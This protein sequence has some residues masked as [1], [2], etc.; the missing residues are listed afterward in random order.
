MKRMTHEGRK[1]LEK[2]LKKKEMIIRVIGKAM[3]RSHSTTYFMEI[4]LQKVTF[5]KIYYL[6]P[7]NIPQVP[8]VELI[9]FSKA[10]V[11]Y[12]I[13][14]TETSIPSNLQAL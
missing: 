7:P 2:Y 5:C 13:E 6:L 4:F 14:S 12:I 10:P 9:I 11:A 8:M 1:V 3:S